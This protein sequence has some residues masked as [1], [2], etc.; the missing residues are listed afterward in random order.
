MQA[1]YIKKGTELVGFRLCTGLNQLKPIEAFVVVNKIDLSSVGSCTREG[2]RVNKG[3][4]VIEL[5]RII[6]L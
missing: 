2:G 6:Q 1:T 3:L 5:L 4:M